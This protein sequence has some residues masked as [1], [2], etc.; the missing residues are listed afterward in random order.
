M[1]ARIP[2]RQRILNPLARPTIR[3]MLN[4]CS[5]QVMI[6]V[7]EWGG[8]GDRLL[9]LEAEIKKTLD[10]YDARYA[11]SSA[12]LAA[13]VSDAKQHG[14]DYPCRPGSG[15]KVLVG[16]EHDIY[17]IAALMVLRGRGF[18]ET[19]LARYQDELCRRIR[20]YNKTFDGAPETVIDVM[21]NRLT[22][23]GKAPSEQFAPV[24]PTAITSGRGYL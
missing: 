5:A 4:R 23:Y 10:E 15:E 24:N 6:E 7:F 17:F 12:E 13:M 8:S 9:Q 20:Y 21:D 19:R 14:I 22:R 1:K 2:S 3:A 16:R 11:D 18:A